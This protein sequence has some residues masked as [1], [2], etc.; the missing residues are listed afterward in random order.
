MKIV[1]KEPQKRFVTASPMK[2]V[3]K[4]SVTPRKVAANPTSIL[5][6]ALTGPQVVRRA[7]V[8]AQ[9]TQRVQVSVHIN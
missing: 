7:V 1:Q 3:V 8:G 5:N 4:M 9:P 2:Q 6:K